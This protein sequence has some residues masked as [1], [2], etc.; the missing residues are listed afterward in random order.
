MPETFR[1]SSVSC[2][3]CVEVNGTLTVGNETYRWDKDLGRYVDVDSFSTNWTGVEKDC[4]TSHNK[5]FV[6]AGCVLPD[7]CLARQ[8]ILDGEGCDSRYVPDV[9]FLSVILFLG[10]FGLAMFC[11]SF[12]STGYFPSWVSSSDNYDLVR[13]I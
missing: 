3:C 13:K 1:A 6:G 2:L 12:R 5:V 10:T 4:F 8:W 9:F 11:R 7:A